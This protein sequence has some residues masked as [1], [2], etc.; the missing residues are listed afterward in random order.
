M[1]ASSDHRVLV[2]DDNVDTRLTVELILSSEGYHVST[3]SNGVEALAQLR[4]AAVLP[5]VILLDLM[6]PLMDGYQ[7]RAEQRSDPILSD[8]P[9]L[10][11]TADGNAEDK[12]ASLGAAGFLRKPIDLDVLVA[13]IAAYC[14]V[15]AGPLP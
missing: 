9:V 15:H 3:A 13:E 1:S 4:T 8:I 12:A 7:F 11:F 10:I 6:M 5:S 2:V 14:S